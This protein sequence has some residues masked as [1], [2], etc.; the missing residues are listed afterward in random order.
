M[1]WE[2]WLT[3]FLLPEPREFQASSL[4]LP[5]P[6]QAPHP[7]GRVASLLE[8]HAIQLCQHTSQDHPGDK[9]WVHR[10]SRLPTQVLPNAWLPAVE[11]PAHRCSRSISHWSFAL[12]LFLLCLSL[13][14]SPLCKDLLG[15]P[16]ARTL[17]SERLWT[18]DKSISPQSQFSI[19]RH[20]WW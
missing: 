7:A 20:G 2:G 4:L 1:R 15:S 5:A 16:P 8:C 18:L 14:S 10:T 19:L 3:L 17:E 13:S 11:V 9:D 12:V 6:T